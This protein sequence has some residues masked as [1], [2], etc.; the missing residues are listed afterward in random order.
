MD[1][2]LLKRLAFL[3]FVLVPFPG[4]GDDGE[5]TDASDD[6]DTDGDDNDDND[7]NSP[8]MK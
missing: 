6:T 5:Q 2:K 8:C 4:C 3:S 7:D 1:S